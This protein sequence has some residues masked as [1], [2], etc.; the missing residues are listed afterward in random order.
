VEIELEALLTAV[1]NTQPAM[2]G[3]LTK[4]VFHE[5]VLDPNKRNGAANEPNKMGSAANKRK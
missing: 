5:R 1:G 3:N 2:A 4:Q